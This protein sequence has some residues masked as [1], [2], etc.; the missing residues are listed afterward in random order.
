MG[1]G[2]AADAS[3]MSACRYIGAWREWEHVSA[4]NGGSESMEEHV[5]ALSAWR[6][7][8]EQSV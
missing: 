3:S 1:G 2:D 4:C 8:E 5:R 6:S 7:V